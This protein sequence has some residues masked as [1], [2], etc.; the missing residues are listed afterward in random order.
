LRFHREDNLTCRIKGSRKVTTQNY[1]PEKE[2][3]LNSFMKEK[4][5]NGKDIRRALQRC[6]CMSPRRIMYNSEMCDERRRERK[7]KFM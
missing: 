7:K 3:D 2:E 6:K 5:Q 1:H 4:E